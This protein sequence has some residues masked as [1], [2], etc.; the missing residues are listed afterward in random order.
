VS[1][2]VLILNLTAEK[3]SQKQSLLAWVEHSEQ[4]HARQT[5]LDELGKLGWQE[6]TIADI[7]ETFIDDYFPPCPSFDAF[8]LA[9]KVGF[10]FRV[11]D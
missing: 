3:N 4:Q 1:N 7:S 2:K 6:I 5:A 8:Q 11:V 10:A 9:R